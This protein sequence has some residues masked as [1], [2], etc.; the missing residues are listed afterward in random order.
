M[1]YDKIVAMNQAKSK[2]KA[3][4]AIKQIEKMLE[5]KERISVT[6]LAKNTGFAKSFFYRNQEV[7]KALDDAQL[8]QGECYNPKKVIFDRALEETNINLKS[9]V[10]KLKKRIKE[11]ENENSRLEKK[12]EELTGELN[13][14][15][16]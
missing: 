6:V 10:M 5:R 7:R 12:V 2:Q 8:Q 4:I 3:D 1:K 13:N 14:Q 16:K 9:A 15:K 11:L